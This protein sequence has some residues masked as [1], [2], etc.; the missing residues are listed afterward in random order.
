MNNQKLFVITRSNL[1]AGYQ[2]VQSTHAAIQFIY[3]HP[4]RA[5]PW[6]NTSNY[7]A[8]LS[9]ENERE[10]IKLIEKC[11]KKKIAYSIFREPDIGNQITAITIE[12]S[13]QSQKLVANLPLTLKDV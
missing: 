8:L 7:L 10:L 3:E 13:E 12:P 4:S 5:G 6:F 11:E 2:V 9:V 1:S